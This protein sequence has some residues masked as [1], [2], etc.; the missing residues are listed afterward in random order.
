[1]SHIGVERYRVKI[2]TTIDP[3]LLRAVDS[4]VQRFPSYSRSR[5]IDDALRLWQERELERQ[6]EEQYAG[7][8]SEQEQEDRSSWR[9]IR[10]AA[11]A[12]SLDTR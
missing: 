6:M 2:S 12:R 7:P 1:M 8:L 10:N 4:F 5:V 11:A 3:E 9:R